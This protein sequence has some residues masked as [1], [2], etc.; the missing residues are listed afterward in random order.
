MSERQ[1]LFGRL[2][3][4]WNAFQSRTPFQVISPDIGRGDSTRPDRTRLT[5][6]NEKSIV[7]SVYTRIAIDVSSLIFKHVKCDENGNYKEDLKTPLN[8]CL[9]LS[10]N[11]DQTPRAFFHDIVMTLFDEGVVAIVPTDTTIDPATSDAYDILTCRVGRI[12]EWYPQMVKVSLYNEKTGKREDVIVPKKLTAIIENPLYAVMND[13]N[14]TL[15]RLIYKL[16]LLDA[17]DTQSSSGKLDIIIQLPYVI[18]TDARKEQAEKRRQDIESQLAGSKYG[19]AY[20]DGTE[21]VTQLNRAAENNLMK[22][23]EYLTS[24]L[25]GQLGITEGVF[26]GK[27]D[28]KEMINY[29]SRTVESIASAIVEEFKRKFLTKTA[30]SQ[31]QSIMYFRNI[32]KLVPVAQL[33]EIADKFTRNEVM[34]GNEIRSIIGLRPSDDPRANKLLNK[35]MNF[36]ENQ[37]QS[38]KK[39]EVKI[40]E[41]GTN[42]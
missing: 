13:P 2:Q 40:D 29:Y 27:A 19:I 24:M 42:V 39:K 16:N 33:A 21:K 9:N 8:N 41:E 4:A 14:S 17:I 31:G 35:N 23:I 32:F 26:S 10:T 18:K 36:E 22:Q 15:K 37:V 6:G 3:H 38:D 28:E 30:I 20:I 25:Y 12:V 1:S 7:S 5:A 34:T 11:I